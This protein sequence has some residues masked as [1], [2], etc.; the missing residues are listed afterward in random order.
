MHV[1]SHRVHFLTCILLQLKLS[2]RI[3]YSLVY[4][5]SGMKDLENLFLREQ[6]ESM[7]SLHGLKNIQNLSETGRRL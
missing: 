4:L 3:H 5:Q 7:M 1:C 2:Y 6:L